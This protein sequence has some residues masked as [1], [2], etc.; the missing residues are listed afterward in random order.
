M[1]PSLTREFVADALSP[2][3]M[4]PRAR[5]LYDLCFLHRHHFNGE[6]VGDKL[7]L[8]GRL[9]AEP[10][11]VPGCFPERGAHCLARSPVDRWFSTLATAE[12]LEGW[13]LLEMHKRVM[14]VFADLAEPE[15]RS[16]AAQYLHFHFPELFY[17]HD[18]EVERAARRLVPGDCGFLAVGD[19]DPAYGRFHARCRKLA[20]QLTPER[21]RR[22]SPRELDRVLR[23]WGA[24]EDAGSAPRPRYDALRS[25]APAF[26]HA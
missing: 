21:G 25:T 23:A 2:S 16:L 14:A 8:I 7:R 11:A 17:I 26:A 4:D 12:Q 1:S 10:G 20:E 24:M 3:A 5:A 18:G 13:L 22:L 9:Y 15:A 19:F 6:L